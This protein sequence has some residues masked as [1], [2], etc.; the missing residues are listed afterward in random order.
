[1]PN[2]PRLKAR[3]PREGLFYSPRKDRLVAIGCYCIMPTH[4]HLLLQPI[5]K[6]G[7][8]EFMHKVGTGFT[9]FYNEQTERVGNLFIKPFRAKHID[10]DVYLEQVVRYIH[11]N[12]A[13]L[14]EPQWKN[15]IVKNMPA[16]ERKLRLY[17]HSSLA[18]HEG[19]ERPE[20]SIVDLHALSR[21][22]NN[23]ANLRET[24]KEAA[25]YYQFL[26][27]DL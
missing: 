4:Y 7:V 22:R 10:D 11:L 14:F 26:E 9:R 19:R 23:T 3:L 13:E 27:L 8:S 5:S 2:I 16:L 1:M 12:P 17:E 18:E 25:E 21:V 15:G 20:S 24:L 6:N